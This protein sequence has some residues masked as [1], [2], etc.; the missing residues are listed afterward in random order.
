MKLTRDQ[1]ELIRNAFKNTVDA[2]LKGRKIR[3]IHSACNAIDDTLWDSGIPYSIFREIKYYFYYKFYPS[4][5][6]QLRYDVDTLYWCE[7]SYLTAEENK[8]FRIMCLLLADQMWQE[9]Y[10]DFINNV[11][12]GHYEQQ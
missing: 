12:W 8:D 1:K 11:E 5:S 4:K 7:S 6:E 2:L 10:K 9:S 3:G